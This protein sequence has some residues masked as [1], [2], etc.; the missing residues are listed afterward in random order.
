MK[1]SLIQNVYYKIQLQLIIITYHI[2][3]ECGLNQLTVFK[4][5]LV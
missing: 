2:Q 3:C 5:G 4:P 1:L